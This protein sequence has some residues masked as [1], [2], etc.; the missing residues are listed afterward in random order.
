[1][2]VREICFSNKDKH[3]III[4]DDD[5][6]GDDDDDDDDNNNEIIY[7]YIAHIKTHYALY[8]LKR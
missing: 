3:Y 8:N 1:M 4:N 6:D 2:T 5:D 7:S